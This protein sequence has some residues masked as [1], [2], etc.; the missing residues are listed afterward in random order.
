[1]RRDHGPDVGHL[2]DRALVGT[3]QPLERAEVPREGER[4]RLADVADTEPVQ[5]SRQGRLLA[6]LDRRQQVRGRFLSHA[7]E[8]R[9]LRQSERVEVGGRLHLVTLD[10]LLD[11]PLAETLDVERAAAREVPQRLLALS[12]AGEAAGAARHRLALDAQHPRAA[13]RT[14]L[15]QLYRPGVL[16]PPVGH[17]AHHFGDH[18]PGAAHHHGVSDPHVLAVHLVDV[19]QRDVA[20]RHAAH[21]HR[22]EPR[23]RRERS[24]AADL[25]LDVPDDGERLVGSKLVGDRP[26]RRARHESEPLLVGAVIEL[27]DDAVDL[28]GERAAPLAQLAIVAEAAR[29]SAHGARVPG[30]RQAE[31]AQ[32]LE[33]LALARRGGGALERPE[34]VEESRER[35]RGGNARVELP[36]APGGRVAR[37]HEHLLAALARLAVHALEAGERH[38]DL[39]ARLEQG[40][41][42]RAQALRHGANG[43]HVGGDVLAGEAVAAR[44]GLCEQPLAVDHRHREPVELRLRDVVEVA[45][46]AETLVD[47][48]VE[49]LHVL[50][51]EGVVERE[52]RNLVHDLAETAARRSRHALRGRVGRDELGM[53]RF[54]RAQFQHQPVVLGVGNQRIIEHV[55]AVVVLCNLRAQ[56][57]RARRRLLRHAPAPAPRRSRSSAMRAGVRGLPC[58]SCSSPW[59]RSLRLRAVRMSSSKVSGGGFGPGSTAKSDSPP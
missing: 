20:H 29:D 52:H 5:Q 34:A 19:V 50:L 45:R 43:A 12:A 14:A 21:E 13:H 36:Q 25:E 42:R 55:V 51:R 27:V 37:I 31:P 57:R 47:A 1:M 46:D 15:R 40:R 11:H 9:E 24:G 7:L 2:L 41:S 44:R 56:L 33:Q 30:C 38:E 53:R 49:G 54:Q 23:H 18:I 32:P 26:A 35:P 48:A 39:P 22:R 58:S 8:L 10:Q 28:I 6:L 16:S 17:H 4:G 3:H 59:R